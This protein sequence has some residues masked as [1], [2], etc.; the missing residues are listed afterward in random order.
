MHFVV[1]DTVMVASVTVI[2]SCLQFLI[3]GITH[4]FSIFVFFIGEKG[5][6]Y[7]AC[8][9][10]F[11]ENNHARTKYARPV[12]ACLVSVRGYRSDMRPL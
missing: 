6:I 10:R 11:P 1:N 4:T 5:R 8:E 12:I 3:P 2:D 9:I 7:K